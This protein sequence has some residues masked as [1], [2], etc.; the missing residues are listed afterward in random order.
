MSELYSKQLIVTGLVLTTKSS[1]R[2]LKALASSLSRSLFDGKLIV[3]QEDSKPLFRIERSLI[4]EPLAGGGNVAPSVTERVLPHLGEARQWVV[5]SSA[6]SIVLR[7]IDHLMPPDHPGPFPPEEIDFYYCGSRG[8]RGAVSDGL[9]AVRSEFVA[10]VL[11]S[12]EKIVGSLPEDCDTR[13]AWS[14]YVA[15]LN[16]RKKP[17][18]SGEVIAPEIDAVR[19]SEISNAAFVI[20]SHWPAKERWKLLQ[21]LYF[22]TFF[23]DESGLMLDILDP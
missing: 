3:F 7:N 8:V 4:E 11:G 22:G 9:W 21:S 13:P 17:F 19:W 10:Q 23:G 20:L 6:G 12:W 16:L 15:G 5:F 14:E 18:E 1:R 2:E